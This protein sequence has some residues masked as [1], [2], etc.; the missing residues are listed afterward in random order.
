MLFLRGGNMKRKWI[1]I[2]GAALLAP[3]CMAL[4]MFVIMGMCWVV[5]RFVILQ[6]LI[7]GGAGLGTLVF[8]WWILYIHC[9]EYRSTRRIK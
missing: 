3:I 2:I 1:C 6:I 4:L 9:E 7:V 8:V 5:D